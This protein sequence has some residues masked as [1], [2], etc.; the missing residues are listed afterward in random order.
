MDVVRLEGIWKEKLLNKGWS[1]CCVDKYPNFLADSTLA[2]YNT[3]LKKFWDFYTSNGYKYPPN[4]SNLLSI[5]VTF[6][7]N[8]S[9]KTDRPESMLKSMTSALKHWILANEFCID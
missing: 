1:K 9:E 7:N 5:I 4:D 8:E 3:C 6:L 2:Q